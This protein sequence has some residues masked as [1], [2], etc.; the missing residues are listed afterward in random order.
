MYGPF[1]TGGAILLVIAGIG[2]YFSDL[3]LPRRV[4][5]PGGTSAKQPR[6]RV[7]MTAC[8]H[9]HEPGKSGQPTIAGLAGSP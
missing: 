5:G 8:C 4:C 1:V 2:L 7:G 6:P 9:G 3:P